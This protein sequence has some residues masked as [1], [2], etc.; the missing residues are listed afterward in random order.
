MVGLLGDGVGGG[1]TKDMLASPAKIIR[2]WVGGGG[3]APL[4]PTHMYYCLPTG[5]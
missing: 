2:G 3:L 5:T 1:G 4:V